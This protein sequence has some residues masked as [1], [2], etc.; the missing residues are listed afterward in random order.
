[1]KRLYPEQPIVGV[2]GIIFRGQEVLLIRR[3]QEPALGEWSLPGG[4]VEVGETLEEAL[5]REVREETGLDI[6][7][8]G[9]TAV[10]NRLVRD[11]AG[12]VAYHYVLLDFLCQ[13]KDGTP[14]A[15]SDS[16]DLALVPYVEL[17]AWPL[18]EQT[19]A[20][21]RQAFQQL[22]YGSYLPPLLLTA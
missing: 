22:L 18:P 10:V 5:R 4:A 12:A 8:I 3:G 17:A 16:T 13:A 6:D 9:L 14:R 11:Q 1:M 20:V 15:G 7:I 2:A 19:R 21:I